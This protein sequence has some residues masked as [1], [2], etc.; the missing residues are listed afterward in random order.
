[1]SEHIKVRDTRERVIVR[2]LGPGIVV[3]P[4][5]ALGAQ[6]GDVLVQLANGNVVAC[7]EQSRTPD[8]MP[9]EIR[10]LYNEHDRLSTIAEDPWATED[11]KRAAARE[12]RDVED[13]LTRKQA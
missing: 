4:Y 6:P 9:A 10:D 12:R 1:M 13:A 2:G 3:G 8:D 7:N 5:T 11:A